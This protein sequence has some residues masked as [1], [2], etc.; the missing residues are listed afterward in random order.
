MVLLRYLSDLWWTLEIPIVNC[1]INFE[2]KW[3]GKCL[4]VAGT[5]ENQ[6]LI[7]TTTDTKLYVPVVSSPTQ[8]YVKLP[9][10]L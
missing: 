8:D 1:K 3:S 2:L 6:V 10:Q 9:K 4:S 7:F 5:V